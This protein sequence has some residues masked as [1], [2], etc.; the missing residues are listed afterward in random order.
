MDTREELRDE[1]TA[2]LGASREL[3]PDTDRYL[4]EGFL[5]R[6]DSRKLQTNRRGRSSNRRSR[7]PRRRLAALLIAGSA[8]VI[9]TPLALHGRS[10]AQGPGAVA[11]VAD[12]FPYAC[13]WHTQVFRFRSSRGFES[14]R[15]EVNPASYRFFGAARSDSEGVVVRGAHRECGTPE[16]GQS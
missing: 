15:R 8:L 3:T 7:H 14:F 1:L 9:G 10:N 5:D 6:L 16:P 2:I 11:M 13:P 12:M 4:A